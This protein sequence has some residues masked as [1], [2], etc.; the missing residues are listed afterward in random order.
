MEAIAKKVFTQEYRN[1]AVKLVT[2]QGLLQSEVGR[3]LKIS[4][5]ML[6]RWVA[7]PRQANLARWTLIVFFLSVR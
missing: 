2:E 6:G 7:Y 3:R 4:S 1:E 5:K